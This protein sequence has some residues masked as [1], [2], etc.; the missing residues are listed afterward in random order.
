[1]LSTR[2]L[3][4]V[5]LA[6]A[7]RAGAAGFPFG[8][9]NAVLDTVNTVSEQDACADDGGAAQDMIIVR[10]T[11]LSGDLQPSFP[12]TSPGHGGGCGGHS[13]G[14]VMDGFGCITVANVTYNMYIGEMMGAFGSGS[15]RL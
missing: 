3:A 5:V 11:R 8:T 10:L 12:L 7:V 9:A 14:P 6:V 1:M 4:A 2:G 15:Y 13:I